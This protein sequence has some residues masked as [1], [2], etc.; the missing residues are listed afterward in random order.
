[1]AASLS[2]PHTNQDPLR[3]VRGVNGTVAFEQMEAKYKAGFLLTVAV[4]LLS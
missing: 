4:I 3:S 2:P 1:M